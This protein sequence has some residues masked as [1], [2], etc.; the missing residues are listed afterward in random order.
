MEEARPATDADVAAVARLARDAIAELAPMRGGAIWRAREARREPL[1][2]SLRRDLADDDA[3]AL[4]G[5]IAGVPLGYAVAR[6]E[7]L[8]D[9]TRLGVVEDIYVDPG[10]REVGLGEAMME[11]LVAW[12]R[13][14]GCVGMDAMALPGH[15]STK[16]FFEESG[17]TARKL[18]M[19]HSLEAEAR[20]E[21]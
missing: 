5:T 14:K 11:D 7:E 17:F 10:A 4:V 6:V 13:Q 1:E 16:N 18:V 21:P 9:G 19:Y 12:C 3:R 15:R 20:P 8:G 2:E